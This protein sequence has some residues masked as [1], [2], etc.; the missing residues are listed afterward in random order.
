M[1]TERDTSIDDATVDASEHIGGGSVYCWT[2]NPRWYAVADR[3]PS[4]KHCLWQ[5]AQMEADPNIAGELCDMFTNHPPDWLV[6]ENNDNELPDFVNQSK[7]N[8]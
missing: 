8:N 5:T 2:P 4:F 1:V 3:F 6:L 7:E